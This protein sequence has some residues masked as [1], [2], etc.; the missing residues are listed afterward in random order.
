MYEPSRVG[1]FLELER[2]GYD[3]SHL[4]SLAEYEFERGAGAR[5]RQP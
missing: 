5:D 2:K 4:R 1:L 3:A